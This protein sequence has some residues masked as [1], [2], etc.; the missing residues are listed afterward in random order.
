[1]SS[2][3]RSSKR[4]VCF[5]CGAYHGAELGSY[6]AHTS[7]HQ[8][9]LARANWRQETQ[10]WPDIPREHRHGELL[11]IAS[12]ISAPEV[13]SPIAPPRRTRPWPGKQKQK[14]QKIQGGARLLLSS[15]LCAIRGAERLHLAT[16]FAPRRGLCSQDSSR[17]RVAKGRA[18]P[19]LSGSGLPETER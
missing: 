11:G 13:P 14:N 5:W 6:F 8:D 4:I 1:M 15:F 17:D 10:L 12:C 2:R 19:Y 7:P 16:S 9:A 3:T 18:R